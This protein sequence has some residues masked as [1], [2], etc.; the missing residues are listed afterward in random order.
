MHILHRTQAQAP[1]SD[2]IETPV[3]KLPTT[4]EGYASLQAELRRRVQLERPRIGE[5]IKDAL[6]DDPN[7]PEN[8]EYQ[9]AKSEQESNE[10]SIAELQDK[11]AR[12]EIIDIW[13]LSGDTVKFGATV[14]VVDEDTVTSSYTVRERYQL[15][16]ILALLLAVPVDR[17]ARDLRSLQPA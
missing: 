16:Y 11:L 10:A 13:K 3:R 7:L 17:R 1:M 15:V 8:T 6:A 12:A 2:D 5:R 9:A 4:A 14:T